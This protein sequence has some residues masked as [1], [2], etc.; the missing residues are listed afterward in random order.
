MSVAK[1]AKSATTTHIGWPMP[2]KAQ[3]A[4]TPKVEWAKMPIL[5]GATLSTMR[6]KSH[7]QSVTPAPELSTSALPVPPLPNHSQPVSIPGDL[8]QVPLKY[9]YLV[10]WEGQNVS[11]G[12]QLPTSEDLGPN[13]D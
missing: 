11:A 9:I 4:Q 10:L 12:I 1:K 5:Q 6:F 2:A 3:R 8:G 13:N 7:A